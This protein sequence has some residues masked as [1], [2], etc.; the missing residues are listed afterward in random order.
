MSLTRV[1]AGRPV[2]APGRWEIDPGFTRVAFVVRRLLTRM[3]GDFAD[4]EGTVAIAEDPMASSA[5][6]AIPAA[7]VRTGHPGT[8]EAAREMLGVEQFPTITF[9]STAVAPG[10][11]DLWTITGELTIRGV[12]RPV[13][14]ATRFVGAAEHPFGGMR[15][16]TFEATATVDRRDF[17]VDQYQVPAPG[18]AGAVVV[19]NVISITLDVEVDLLD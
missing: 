4:V 7:T 5:T 16:A 2:P 8:D 11:A 1:V 6:I 13:D 14:L 18:T 12:T 17:G 10:E 15:K 3:R 19:G 9:T